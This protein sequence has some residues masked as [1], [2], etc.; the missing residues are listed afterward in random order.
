[1]RV[2][3]QRGLF[4]VVDSAV[5]VGIGGVKSGLRVG[6]RCLRIV[7]NLPG[8]QGREL[9]FL[10]GRDLA[11]ARVRAGVGKGRLGGV[12]RVQRAEVV[13]FL[14]G[15]VGLV[16]LVVTIR[17]AVAVAAA[18]AVPGPG[19]GRDRAERRAVKADR[20]GR[21]QHAGHTC[22]KEKRETSGRSHVGWS[23]V[24]LRNMHHR[25]R[26]SAADHGDNGPP[27]SVIR[28]ILR[29]ANFFGVGLRLTRG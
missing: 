9:R 22:R 21:Q 14:L 5:V 28:D 8:R 23:F 24:L 15:L 13:L 29:A 2:G 20:Q 1:L 6:Q 19:L 12:R 16:A 18:V 17:V 26:R 7:D 3:R 11:D 25:R 10:V 4:G 27:A